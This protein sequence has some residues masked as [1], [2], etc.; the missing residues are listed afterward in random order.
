VNKHPWL[1]IAT[2]AAIALGLTAAGCSGGAGGGGNAG[3]TTGTTAA[4]GAKPIATSACEPIYY[5]GS[6]TPNYVIASDLPLQ[7][8]GQGQ[9]TQM[10]A[11]IRYVLAKR[12][13]RAGTFTIGYQECDDSTAEA[14]TYAPARCT[15]NARAYAR[16]RSLIG[17]IGTYNS[18]CAQL[19]IPIV[20]RAAGGPI[21]MIS[22]AN[23]RVGLTHSGFGSDPDEPGKYYPTGKRNY[24]RIVATDE[25]QGASD[26]LMFQKLGV[27]KVFLLNDQESY[28]V[29][30]AHNVERVLRALGIQIAGRAAWNAKASSY[31]ALARRIESSDA[32]GVFLGGLVENNGGRLIKDLRSVLGSKVAIVAPD[33][34]MPVSAVIAGGGRAAN[35]VIVSVAGTFNSRL[36]AKGKAFVQHF[37]ATQSA[38]VEPYTLYAAQAAEILLDAIAHSDGSRAQVIDNLFATKV[39]NGI[40]GTFAI[41]AN[42]DIDKPTYA[43]YKVVDGRRTDFAVIQAPQSLANKER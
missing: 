34:F 40:L 39:T 27:E 7:G 29:G 10:G 4:D 8:S 2:A 38:R 12:H 33:G 41:N 30:I 1:G 36:G 31:D 21:P 37:G 5:R 17:L 13:F 23:V 11:A 35:G 28:G 26:G 9:T 15:A 18:P 25:F 19:V 32:D 42:G 20:N 43:F 14:G 16:T 6:G 3:G 24:V 22:P